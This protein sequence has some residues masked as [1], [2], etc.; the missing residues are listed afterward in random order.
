MTGRGKPSGFT[1]IKIK[2]EV[3]NRILSTFENERKVD[4]DTENGECGIISTFKV[5]KRKNTEE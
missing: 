2:F 1:K 5:K 3:E 4:V